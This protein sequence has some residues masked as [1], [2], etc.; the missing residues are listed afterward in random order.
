[1]ISY[2]R[3]FL[4]LNDITLTSEQS[5]WKRCADEMCKGIVTGYTLKRAPQVYR[6]VY[7]IYNHKRNVKLQGV[8]NTIKDRI[9]TIGFR[10]CGGGRFMRRLRRNLARRVLL[11]LKLPLD[12]VV[13][14]GAFVA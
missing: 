12:M 14:I 6:P 8:L 13:H 4:N 1:M 7:N 2:I 3:I 5:V 9:G 10:G 11:G